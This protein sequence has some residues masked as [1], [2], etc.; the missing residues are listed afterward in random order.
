MAK[1]RFVLEPDLRRRSRGLQLY[2]LRGLEFFLN[3]SRSAPPGCCGRALQ[4][5]SAQ[6][7]SIH[8]AGIDD[9]KAAL[10]DRFRLPPVRTGR[11]GRLAHLEALRSAS[12][13]PMRLV[14]PPV[15]PNRCEI[16]QTVWRSIP[17]NLRPLH[18]PSDRRKRRRRLCR[19]L[20]RLS[21]NGGPKSR[22]ADTGW[23][24]D[25]PLDRKM[26]NRHSA[27]L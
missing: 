1:A 10:V 27:D 24:G 7:S 9:A 2:H 16:P 5:A 21:L 25:P 15:P 4:W 14:R 20:Q 11:S 26:S 17:P 23:H 13:R 18:A 22:Q 6:L 19:A 8:R 12:A 3:A